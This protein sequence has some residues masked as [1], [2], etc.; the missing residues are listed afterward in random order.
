MCTLC[1]LSVFGVDHVC[2]LKYS[3]LLYYWRQ[4]YVWEC[5]NRGSIISALQFISTALVCISTMLLLYFAGAEINA[6]GQYSQTR[7]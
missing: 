6:V 3:V 4:Y 5:K 2:F 1:V 7:C